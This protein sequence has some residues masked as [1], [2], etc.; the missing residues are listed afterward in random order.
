MT[1]RASLG[2]Q[3]LDHAVG[4][5]LDDAEG[6][7]ERLQMGGQDGGVIAGLL[8]VEVHGN[9]LEANRC[10]A[11]QPVQDIEQGPGILAAGQANHD[12][13][14]V[15]DHRVVGNCLAHLMAQVTLKTG[16]V[17]TAVGRLGN[18]GRVHLC[19]W[20]SIVLNC[21]SSPGVA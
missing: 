18:H 2:H 6:K 8:L 15:L 3:A 13:I 12:A 16:E 21:A 5:L 7:A 20:I 14:A 9:Q 10:A 17:G 4:V 11:L 19:H 1:G